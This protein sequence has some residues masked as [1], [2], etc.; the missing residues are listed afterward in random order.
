MEDSYLQTYQLLIQLAAPQR[1]RIGRL[2]AFS[3][4]AGYYVYTGSA[5]RHLEARVSRHLSRSKNLHW[6]IDYLVAA[7]GTQVIGV[8]RLSEAEC[9][10]A[11]GLHGLVVVP[12]F[13]ASDCQA[14]CGSHLKYLGPSA[15]RSLLSFL[16][17]WTILVDMPICER[18]KGKNP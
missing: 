13:G 5:R 15:P 17:T 11:G 7:P 4:P 9:K 14:R 3:F 6:H 1:L 18:Q 8:R 16:G 2:G 10:V 12:G